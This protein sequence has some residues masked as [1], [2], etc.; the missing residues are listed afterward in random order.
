MSGGLQMVCFWL[1]GWLVSWSVVCLVGWDQVVLHYP[2]W[3]LTPR[4]KWS[5]YLS[6][7]SS[8]VWRWAPLCPASLP[9]LVPCHS[10]CSSLMPAPANITTCFLLPHP[11]LAFPF[12]QFSLQTL[13]HHP[14]LTLLFLAILVDTALSL[15]LINQSTLIISLLDPRDA[16][17]K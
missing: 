16:F 17:S 4:L 10:C 3:S 14:Q 12:L 1:V 2:G 8:L 7:L 5:S 13:A 6:F 9:F 15:K 11:Q